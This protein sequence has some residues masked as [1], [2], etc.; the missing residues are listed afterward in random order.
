MHAVPPEGPLHRHDGDP[1]ADW[2]DQPPSESA[3]DHKPNR[4]RQAVATR[5]LIAA[6][7]LVLLLV[8]LL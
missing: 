4:R 1:D 2:L 8:V 7:I 6:G 5:L 3:V